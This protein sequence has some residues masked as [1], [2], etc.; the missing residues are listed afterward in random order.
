MLGCRDGMR[1]D[2]KGMKEELA[3]LLGSG[4]HLC[5]TMH[6]SQVRRLAD[7]KIRGCQ[8]AVGRHKR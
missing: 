7:W 6:D 2:E 4:E 8:E 5:T 3:F 1:K